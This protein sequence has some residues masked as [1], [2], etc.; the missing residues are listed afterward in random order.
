MTLDPFVPDPKC[1]VCKGDGTI[2]DAIG[3]P[4][5][6]ACR[7]A[8]KRDPYAPPSVGWV[9]DALGPV[10]AAAA[11][12][13]ADQD[14]HAAG[15]S[16][17]PC[18]R[19]ER[20]VCAC[21]K[22]Y[23]GAS[24]HRCRDC[25]LDSKREQALAPVRV[26]VPKRFQWALG[27]S[28]ETLCERVKASRALIERALVAPPS[29]DMLL[30]GDTAMGKTSLATAMLYAWVKADPERRTGA[31]F[32]DAYWLAGAR[33]RHSL[34]QGEAPDVTKAMDAT[35]LVLDDV[36]SEIDDKRNVIQDIIFHRHNE[37]RPTWITTGWTPEQ[38]MNRYGSQVLRRIVENAKR[39]ELGA[40]K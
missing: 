11:K 18:K 29:S 3:R 17:R 6:C 36:G 10:M 34:G 5:N 33:A 4:E 22:P 24:N 21:G 39:V 27:A 23:D 30:Q 13:Q 38:L 31:R 8:P 35:L 7:G 25:W 40:K 28:V 37:E 32:A 15:C 12:R 2:T 14:A 20:F 9:G 1:V 26:S 16:E 19:C